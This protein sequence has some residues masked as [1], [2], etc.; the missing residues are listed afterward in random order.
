MTALTP[1]P[2]LEHLE[3]HVP[4]ALE[5]VDPEG[6]HQVRVAGR[7][8]RVLLELGERRALVEDLRWLVRALSRTRDLDVLRDVLAGAGGPGH[9]RFAEWLERLAAE[10]RHDAEAALTSPR[11]TGLLAAL[12]VLS[13]I[14]EAVARRGLRKASQRARKQLDAL[15]GAR[16]EPGALGPAFHGLRRALRRLRYANDWL[17]EPSDGLKHLQDALGALC[18]VAALERLVR[19]FAET[20]GADVSAAVARLEAAQAALAAQ[21]LAT[22]AAFAVLR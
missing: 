17:G 13:P 14:D 20:S 3:R 2:W 7:R 8:L 10:A 6:V 18:D 15:V 11:L 1:A 22:P 19:E 16:L 5:G 21:L 12:E 9:E 4:I